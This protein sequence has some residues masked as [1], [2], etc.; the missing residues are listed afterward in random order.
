MAARIEDPAVRDQLFREAL[1]A[2]ARQVTADLL[3]LAGVR[4]IS[5]TL[6]D[7]VEEAD[8]ALAGIAAA[9]DAATQ[10]RL[11]E[12]ALSRLPDRAWRRQLQGPAGAPTKL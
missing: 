7:A 9:G 6:L 2:A 3:Q 11:A 10:T 1:A 12:A 4:A 5:R 8:A